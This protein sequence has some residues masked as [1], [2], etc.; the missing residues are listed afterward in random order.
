MSKKYFKI[1]L[2]FE[3][4]Q[5]RYVVEIVQTDSKEEA[6]QVALRQFGV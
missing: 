2:H 3:I 1:P 6:K 5:K 4:T